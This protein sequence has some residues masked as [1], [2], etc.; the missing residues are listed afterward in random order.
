VRI[1]AACERQLTPGAIRLA[2][3]RDS[4]ALSSSID[5]SRLVYSICLRMLRDPFEAEDLTQE[6]FVLLLRK[7]HTFRGE[8]VFSSWLYR[9]TTKLALMRSRKK[10]PLADSLDEIGGNAEGGE[11]RVRSERLTCTPLACSTASIFRRL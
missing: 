7:F 10:M 6:T 5:H 11:L 3:Q 1:K 8:S 4:A 9:L 2:H